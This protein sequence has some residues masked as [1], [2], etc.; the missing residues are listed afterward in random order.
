MP[1]FVFTIPK[2]WQLAEYVLELPEILEVKGKL[3]SVKYKGVAK[4]KWIKW[5]GFILPV[6]NSVLTELVNPLDIKCS[7]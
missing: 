6:A 7:Q 2:I 3:Q 4:F 5:T 1:S